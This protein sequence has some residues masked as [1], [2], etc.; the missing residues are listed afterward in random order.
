MDYH[1]LRRADNPRLGQDIKTETAATPKLLAPEC[2]AVIVCGQKCM[3]YPSMMSHVCGLHGCAVEQAGGVDFRFHRHRGQV[4]RCVH[5][6]TSG[7]G[8]THS[9]VT[10]PE[11]ATMGGAALACTSSWVSTHSILQTLDARCYTG[12]LRIW[13][14]CDKLHSALTSHPHAPYD[15]LTRM[16]IQWQSH[17]CVQIFE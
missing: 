14:V 7:I 3:G 4:G 2:I 12:I 11:C 6:A 13:T 16:S 15:H 10:V 5:G 17:L 9:Q 8:A 1:G